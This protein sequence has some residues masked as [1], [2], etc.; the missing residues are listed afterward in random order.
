MV[1]FVVIAICAVV[2]FFS[3]V[4]QHG[5]PLLGMQLDADDQLLLTELSGEEVLEA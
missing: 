2:F 5:I 4:A 1:P 3:W